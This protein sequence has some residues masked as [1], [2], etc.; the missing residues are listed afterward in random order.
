MA[1]DKAILPSLFLFFFSQSDGIPSR[2]HSSLNSSSLPR[3]FFQLS[4]RGYL[5]LIHDL[6]RLTRPFS[7][8]ARSTWVAFSLEKLYSQHKS[9]FHDLQHFR[10][11]RET[12]SQHCNSESYKHTIGGHLL[13][14]G[15]GTQ[16]KYQFSQTDIKFA[17]GHCGPKGI[18]PKSTALKDD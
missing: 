13:I 4:K 12:S 2:I 11:H 16:E 17:V 5:Q 10:R 9:A 8:T 1:L 3:S 18:K 15:T 6:L 14:K 7:N